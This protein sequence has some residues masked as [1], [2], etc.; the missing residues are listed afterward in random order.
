MQA[1]HTHRETYFA[2]QATTTRK[3]VLPFLERHMTI[4]PGTRVLEIGCGEGGN[5][6]PFVERRCREVVGMD[7][8]R[9]K[10][11]K[12]EDFPRKMAGGTRRQHPVS[13]PIGSLQRL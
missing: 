10:N 9:K 12:R 3:H 13:T 6:V 1:R 8:A 11:R 2:E 7:L 4:G 5:L